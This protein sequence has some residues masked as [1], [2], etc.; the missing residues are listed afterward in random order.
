M[1]QLRQTRIFLQQ[2]ND[3]LRTENEAM[4]YALSTPY[5]SS[6]I[7]C[8]GPIV[9]TEEN[10][11]WLENAL[12]RSEIDT[13]TCFIRKLNSFINLYPVVGVSLTKWHYAVV[14]MTSLSLKEVISLARQ[15][16]PMWTCNDRLNLDEYYSNFFPW[17]ARNAPGFVH[18]ASRAYAMVPFDASLLVENLTNHVSWQKIFPSIIADVSLESH[19]RVFQMINVNFVQQISP[20]IQTRNVKL[21]RRSMRIENNTWVIVD[22]SMYFSSYARHSRPNFMRF[23][24]GYLV[25]QIANGISKVTVLD[26]WVYQEEEVIKN[27]SSNSRFGAHRWLAALQRHCYNTWSVSIS[28]IGHQIQICGPI[29]HTNLLNLS[30]WMVSIF[31]T[32]VCGT[33]RQKWKRLSTIGFSVH[34]IRMFTRESRDM[35]GIPWGFVSATGMARMQ[36]TQ[37]ILF[38]LINRAKKQDIWENLA[39]VKD[40]KELI[41]IKRCPNP[42]NEVSVFCIEC[43]GPKEW[44]LIQETYYEASGAMIIYACIEAPCFTAIINGE[45]LSRI[46]ILPFGFT[47]IPNGLQEIFLSAACQ[48]KINQTILTDSDK[49]MEFMRNMI[50]DT[51]E[52]VQNIGS[53]NP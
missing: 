15:G 50:D 39:S 48:V 23:P 9:S 44:Y 52:N 27:F 32:G 1:Y 2:Q 22:I 43:N 16:N 20:L 12:L 3:L 51:L 35:N 14:A 42:G 53:V 5:T 40:M 28:S 31:C 26:H 36:V 41:R 18:E 25:E 8:S 29:C 34:N 46:E 17:Y 6:C 37:E 21:L 33:T 45:D 4:V 11:L 19:N 47:I 49:L 24:S 10:E 13:L 38:R 30:T 7:S